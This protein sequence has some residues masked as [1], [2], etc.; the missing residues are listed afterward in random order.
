MNYTGQAL[1][2]FFAYREKHGMDGPFTQKQAREYI[3]YRHN[4]GLKWQTINGDYSAMYKFYREVMGLGWDVQHIPRPRKERS[5]PPVLSQS[6][7]GGHF[8]K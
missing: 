2:Q 4:Q 6:M 8:W 5:L 1:R 7:F 3:L